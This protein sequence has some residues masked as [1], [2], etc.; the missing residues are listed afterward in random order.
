MPFS[1]SMSYDRP[2]SLY[3]DY[4]TTAGETLVFGQ[5]VKYG[6]NNDTITGVTSAGDAQIIGVCQEDVASSESGPAK[7]VTVRLLAAGV[8][9]MRV[10]AAVTL[11]TRVV[12]QGSTGR[13]AD[14]GAAAVG[15]A[16]SI[17]GQA[18]GASAVAGDLVPVL[19]KLPPQHKG[20]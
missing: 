13:I 6:A 14:I 15:D 20:P 7:R 16:R 19:M 17:V 3:P 4:A 8:V 10:G 18:H 2:D 11:G 12:C 9:A 1:P 5:L